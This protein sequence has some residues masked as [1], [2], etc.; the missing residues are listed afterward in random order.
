MD[1]FIKISEEVLSLRFADSVLVQNI[2][3]RITGKT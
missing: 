1:K 3:L 2:R